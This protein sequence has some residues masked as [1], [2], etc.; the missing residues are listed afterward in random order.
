MEIKK[1]RYWWK[2]AFLRTF[3]VAPILLAKKTAGLLGKGAAPRKDPERVALFVSMELLG[4]GILI[5]SISKTVKQLYPKSRVFLVG[6]QHRAGK[7]E[8]FYTAHSWVD[9]VIICPVRGQTTFS[10]WIRFYRK[11]RSYKLDM[12]ILSPNHSCSDSVWL[13]L[14]G[15]RNIVGAYLPDSWERHGWIE[16]RF[17][18]KKLTR[19]QMS[20][21]REAGYRL[22]YFPRGYA[23]TLTG[24]VD[25][26]LQDLVPFLRYRETELP[27]QAK[28]PMVT[29]HPGGPQKKRWHPEGYAA[30]GRMMVQRFGVTILIIGGPPEA[31]L[32][33][34]VANDI[35]AACP[36]GQVVNC[37]GSS[38]NT[39]INCIARS[40]MYIGNSAGPIYLAMALGTPIVG[41]FRGKDRWF[42]GPDA[43]GDQHRLVSNEFIE[44]ISIS[45]VWSTV[46]YRWKE[47]AAAD[48]DLSDPIA[49]EQ[50]VPVA[51][52]RAAG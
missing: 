32:G 7:L 27:G 26:E 15:I 3:V 13:Y 9:E 5:T 18:S 25:M 48:S 35:L 47:I 22:M 4:G 28:G 42:S 36:E 33:E 12:C 39:T 2:R 41:V 29:M 23:R 11:L 14:I 43:C 19:A 49:A 16:N 44:R 52:S 20:L 6:E 45:E 40:K 37:C 34:Q 30:I 10:D 21:D 8:K 46:Q 17:L 1:A 50:Q 31:E 24:N 38:M 51:P